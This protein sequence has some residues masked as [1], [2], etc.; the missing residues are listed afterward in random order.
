MIRGRAGFARYLAGHEFDALYTYVLSTVD[1]EEIEALPGAWTRNIINLHRVNDV[2][3]LNPYFE[4][5]HRKL[6][7][8]GLFIGYVETFEPRTPEPVR[9]PW[10]SR[11]GLRR[12]AVF[13]SRRVLPRLPL[14]RPL[15]FAVT[16]GR[17]RVLSKTE[18]LGRLVCCGFEIV[19][20]R[21]IGRRLY[22]TVRKDREPAFDR[23]ASYGL[24]FK[25]WRVGEGGERIRV[26]KLR[27]MYAYAEYLQD[28]I[29]RTNRLDASGKFRED[30]RVTGWGRL[31]RKVWIDELPMLINW[32]RRE[33]KLVGVRPLSDQYLSLYPPAF[34]E[35]RLRYRPGL[36]PPYYADLPKS[37]SD[38]VAS[39]ERYLAAYDRHPVRTDVRY[40]FKA[41]YNILCK[42]ARS[43]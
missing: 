21:E 34:A 2:R 22:F 28:Y 17:N 18:V 36:V 4:A 32:F 43:G 24:I 15:Y 31:L 20:H 3:H 25:M 16:K 19:D 8:G 26:Y 40:F 6:E 12:L 1:P 37:F 33:L 39:E 38:I 23:D 27:T 42:R 10:L 35:R 14:T 30:F 29:Y 5:V 7:W 13:L 9:R 41:C 11:A